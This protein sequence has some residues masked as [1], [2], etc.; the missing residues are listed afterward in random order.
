MTAALDSPLWAAAFDLRRYLVGFDADA[1]VRSADYRRAVSRVDPLVFALIFLPH[2]LRGDETGGRITFSEFHL[3]LIEQAK[4]WIVPDELPSQHRDAYVAPRAS[5]KS[6][7]LF[8][9]LPLRAAAHG[10][11]K[12]IAAFADSAAQ[13]EMHLASFKRAVAGSTPAAP[14]SDVGIDL[15]VPVGQLAHHKVGGAPGNPGA[16][17]RLVRLFSGWCAVPPAL[18]VSRLRVGRG[19]R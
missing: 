2:H 4:R 8:F 15:N 6:T 14:T 9:V 3:D 18:E 19:T 10:W 16:R 12:F 5:G 13:A 7:W 17:A 11:R 1:L